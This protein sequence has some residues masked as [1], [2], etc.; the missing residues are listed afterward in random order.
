M[1]RKPFIENFSKKKNNN[2][3]Q[4]NYNQ[5]NIN[6]NKNYFNQNNFYKKNELNKNLEVLNKPKKEYTQ[7]ERKKLAYIE[8]KQKKLE[9][10]KKM[11]KYTEKDRLSTEYDKRKF[12]MSIVNY[13]LN[14]E[15][16]IKEEEKRKKIELI[17]KKKEE[18]EEKK[19]KKFFS[20]RGWS[21]SDSYSSERKLFF[22]VNVLNND[23]LHLRKKE[24]KK[25]L[26]KKYKKG[27]MKYSNNFLYKII[28]NIKKKNLNKKYLIIKRNFLNFY[29]LFGFKKKKLFINKNN[30]SNFYSF[31][32]SLNINEIISLKE[33]INKLDNNY[34]IQNYNLFY[35]K[36]LLNSLS[37]D[38]L[39]NNLINRKFINIYLL[40]L[41]N[42]YKK[43]INIKYKNLVY[44]LRI[45]KLVSNY[46]FTVRNEKF[47]FLNNILLLNNNIKFSTFWN[48]FFINKKFIKIFYKKGISKRKLLFYIEKQKK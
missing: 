27:I 15:K 45:E 16:I 44:F 24:L 29:K 7:E 2:Y 25:K 28:S 4:N 1:K 12:G 17:I 22:R 14:H 35:Y 19:M 10:Q 37:L 6:Q 11:E 26:L 13:I 32:K 33:K 30:Y 21:L 36:E 9:K 41:N 34:I 43:N 23:L 5:N 42:K 8:F 20:D 48:K 38:L 40:H 18:E 3:N 47:S 39:K 46:S 31:F